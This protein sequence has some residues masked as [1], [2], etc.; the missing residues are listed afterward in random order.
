[1]K[2]II[3][4]FLLATTVASYAADAGENWAKN[5][6]MCHG[7]DGS[8]NTVMGKKNGAK[9]YTTAAGQGFSDDAAAKAIKDG[10]AG[11]MKAFGDKLSD[12]D[13]KALV[14]HVRAFKK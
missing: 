13:I 3:V 9:D 7:K 2:K 1:M 11:K 8:G 14:A 10:V 6:A 4:L 12:A 5:C